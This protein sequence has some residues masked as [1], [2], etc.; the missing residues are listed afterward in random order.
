MSS[1]TKKSKTPKPRTRQSNAAPLI[2]PPPS[3]F[4]PCPSFTSPTFSSNR[5]QERT[6]FP[7]SPNP[8]QPLFPS[9]TP[10]SKQSYALPSTSSTAPLKKPFNIVASSFPPLASPSNQPKYKSFTSQEAQTPKEDHNIELPKDSWNFIL[11]I[12][13]EYQQII[14][15]LSLVKQLIPPGWEH[16]KTE[17]FKT[18]TFY[19]HILVDTDS[20]LVTHMACSQEPNRIGYSKVVIK[21]IPTPSQWTAQP[22]FTRNFSV[23]FKP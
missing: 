22:W 15:T 1:P 2:P 14:N 8:F 21:Q 11:L 7:C 16:P 18:Q 10:T 19:E 5:P 6:P 3:R 12:E 13:P 23:T 4:L 20:I 9:P 17:I